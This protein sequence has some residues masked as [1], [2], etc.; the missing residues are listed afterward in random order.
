MLQHRTEPRIFISHSSANN[1]AAVVLFDWLERE[2]WKDEIFLD[3]DPEHGITA[4][5]RWEHK[6]NET[7]N[8]CEAIEGGAEQLRPHLKALADKLAPVTVA[9]PETVLASASAPD[10]ASAPESD[11]GKPIPLTLILLI[12]Q[13]E[14]L[15]RAEGLAEGRAFLKL[16]RRIPKRIKSSRGNAAA[17]RHD[18]VSHRLRHNFAPRGDRHLREFGIQS[19]AG[20]RAT[21]AGDGTVALIA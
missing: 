9:E 4:G 10:A 1:D 17:D 12:D 20:A 16:L 7:A 18:E 8:R 3:L 11:A 19:A 5:Q 15:F 13:G 6:L 14:E 21:G 2:G